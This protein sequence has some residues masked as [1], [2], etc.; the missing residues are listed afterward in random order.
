[1]LINYY[2]IW[3]LIW[4][5]TWKSLCSYLHEFTVNRITFLFLFPSSFL[6]S[7]VFLQYLSAIFCDYL[8]PIPAVTWNRFPSSF[9]FPSLSSCLEKGKNT[10]FVQLYFLIFFKNDVCY[11]YL[12]Y[13]SSSFSR[14]PFPPDIRNN[15][16]IHFLFLP[17][18]LKRFL[19]MCSS[20]LFAKTMLFY[21]LNWFM[22]R[23]ILS[24][25]Y[26][27]FHDYYLLPRVMRTSL[28]P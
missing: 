22:L 27:F 7:F 12:L 2:E 21:C 24:N 14:F 13:F 20:F 3:Q 9:C 19:L 28:P 26:I 17:I 6:P 16:R 11:I 15:R 5:H 8:L 18:F 1:M 23:S 4:I 25:L 10:S